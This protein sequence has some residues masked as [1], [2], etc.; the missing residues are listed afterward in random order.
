[1]I[2]YFLLFVILISFSIPAFAQEE[3]TASVVS[4]VKTA[5]GQIESADDMATNA[6]D[7]AYE[8]RLKLSKDMH[9]IWPVRPK[10]EKAL[11]SIAA[12]ID[13]QERARFKAAMRK[14]INFGGVEQASIEAMADIFTAEELT[15]MIAFYGSKE[16]RSVSFKTDDYQRAL[17]P[18]L[19]K[20]I[21]KAILDTKLGQ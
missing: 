3:G 12:Q 14:A 15:A 16:G 21:D 13:A 20:M 10:I 8:A 5:E 17:Q 18:V 9:E 4:E 7:A 2:R 1:M 19:V 6:Q 11:D